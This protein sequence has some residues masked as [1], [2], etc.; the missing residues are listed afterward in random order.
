VNPRPRLWSI[1]DGLVEL[2]PPVLWSWSPRHSLR[3]R[4]VAF[5][6]QAAL[7]A[8]TRLRPVRSAPAQ[9]ASLRAAVAVLGVINLMSAILSLAAAPPATVDSSGLLALWQ[10]QATIIGL[11]L[12][13]TVF[14]LE[15]GGLTARLRRDLA[16]S[17]RVYQAA[18][19]GI[20]LVILTGEAV[21]FSDLEFGQWLQL[22]VWPASLAWALLVLIA[23]REV[24]QI[25]DPVHR[26]ARRRALLLQQTDEG[27]HAELVRNVGQSTLAKAL[28]EVG[29]VAS[30]FGSPTGELPET[31]RARSPRKG[32]IRDLN[33]R[34][35]LRAARE[36]GEASARLTVSI[37]LDE[38]VGFDSLLA[39]STRALPS[40][41]K[42]RIRRAVRIREPKAV[43]DIAS[44]I[45]A[46][47]LEAQTSMG[48]DTTVLEAVCETYEAILERYA[49]GWR[50]YV[51][52]LEAEHINGFRSSSG[53]PLVAVEAA[54]YQLTD[55]AVG[56][57]A[58]DAV[59]QL[60]YFPVRIL[61]RAVTWQAPA[62]FRLLT[63]YPALYRFL[64]HVDATLRGRVGDRPW[65]H[66]VEALGFLL[67]ISLPPY[68]AESP[69]EIVDTARRAIRG[70]LSDVLRLAVRAEDLGTVSEAIRRW[71]I[72]EEYRAP[73]GAVPDALRFVVPVA[74]ET[75]RGAFAGSIAN[76]R[77]L[78]DA[79]VLDGSLASVQAGLEAQ[80][81]PMQR[82]ADIGDWA[83]FD[84][85]SHEA[86]FVDTDTDLMRAFLLAAA[87]HIDPT[88]SLASFRVT[89]A[90]Y[91]HREALTRVADE[92]QASPARA[93]ELFGIV[94]LSGRIL[95]IRTAWDEGVRV[96]ER[97]ER[98][99]V[100]ST[101]IDPA[102]VLNFQEAVAAS[103]SAG[104][105]QNWFRASGVIE[106]HGRGIRSLVTSAWA[107]KTFFIAGDVVANAAAEIGSW[108]ARPLL[109]GELRFLRETAARLRLRTF[110]A[111]TNV[112]RIRAAIEDIELAACHHPAI[113]FPRDWEL[114]S[115]LAS[116]GA[117]AFAPGAA[118]GVIG[119]FDGLPVYDLGDPDVDWALV[120]CPARGIV[121]RQPAN[122]L[123]AS[124][125]VVD[126]ARAESL[127][128]DGTDGPGDPSET[129]AERLQLRVE[130]AV[131]VGLH[132]RLK[133]AG[134]RRIR[135]N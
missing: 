26:V 113:F 121:V 21:V 62:Y 130:I 31:S 90:L 7:P 118:E 88:A 23:I 95:R 101:P 87:V 25:T 53:A 122:A 11:A 43:A 60:A 36:E 74:W 98:D 76:P 115:G 104:F 61:T 30:A 8:A 34:A 99:A 18:A 46:L 50:Q 45:E 97:A 54:M 38:T 71:R 129:A 93:E 19:I 67:P 105:P 70:S 35:M 83:M 41:T 65:L 1:V 132:L 107:D 84:M 33:L 44:G 81:D 94:D 49:L 48:P 119:T 75:V 114:L 78:L 64:G 3:R 51:P 89:R 135:L 14:V 79:S 77:A 9:L 15:S 39:E 42:S 13:L 123:D 117:F 69:G 40:G 102:Q 16:A 96:Y 58:P 17:T 63:I 12:A 125:R 91:D 37:R 6:R 72:A 103:W 22:L 127:V 52:A 120:I 4:A 128:R 124:V 126:T 32:Q 100:R 59:F 28:E 57:S 56:S 82:V 86:G 110:G 20:L 116:H 133:S 55:A 131:S 73:D 2:T 27:L 106:H 111:S 29:G 66:L 80:L 24:V 10:V 68:V 112:G 108:T 92:L 5:L 85:K 109:E 47:R 134:V